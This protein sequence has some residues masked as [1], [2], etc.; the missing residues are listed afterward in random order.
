[1]DTCSERSQ[2]AAMSSSEHW[3]EQARTSQLQVFPIKISQAS[4]GK[5]TKVPLTQHGHQDASFDVDSFDWSQAN[6][7]GVAM[8]E[9]SGLYALDIDDY[10]TGSDPEVWFDERRIPRE[11]RTHKTV[12][13]G[14]HRIYA[15]P[16]EW[17]SLGN[18]QNIVPGL[19]GRGEGGWIAFGDG[20]EV[21]DERL[22]CRL[23]PRV[24]EE[25]HREHS[26]ETLKTAN[27][28]PVDAEELE[29]KL[30]KAIGGFVHLKRRWEGDTTGLTDASA[31]G[32]DMSVA[33]LLAIQDF[34]Y[35]EIVDVLLN[36]FPNGQARKSPHIPQP[37]A[38]QRCAQRAIDYKTKQNEQ[39]NRQ[40]ASPKYRHEGL[41]LIRDSNRKP[42]WNIAN[43]LTL[44]SDHEEWEGVLA[45]NK[46]SLR[47]E[48]L[49]SVPGQSDNNYP[50]ALED[51]DYASAQAWFNRN[52]F[53]KADAATVRAAVQKACKQQSFDPLVDYL[54]GLQWDGIPRLRAWLTTYAGAP[55]SDYIAEVGLRWCISAVA[56]A[57]R[58]GCKADHMLVLEG[59]QGRKKS[60]ALAAL[61]GEDWF[62]D[63]LPQMGTKD[64]Q[65][66][67]RGKWIIEVGELEAMRR[68]VDAIKAFISRQVETYR[69]AYGR[70]EVTEQR[71]CVF[72]GTTNK[73]DWQ[74]DETGGRR[75]WP[76]KVG[77]IDVQSL[78]R[79]RDQLWAEAVVH[80]QNGE[81]WWL[82][83]EVVETAKAEV[84]ARQA[85]DPWHEDIAAIIEGKSEITTKQVLSTIGIGTNDM[86]PAL[87]KRVAKE[88][89][90]LGW[91]R[92]GRATRGVHKGRAVYVPGEGRVRE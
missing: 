30:Q 79:D 37:R 23:Q 35:D 91:Q 12:S 77:A 20:Y 3:K 85:D 62:S 16:R 65:S 89:V 92:Q 7:Y 33:Q 34:T 78:A 55:A 82:E 45:F 74:R 69:P 56:R 81:S 54:D 80:F 52:G 60:T 88:L 44:L 39:A 76:V 46:F 14:V 27:A 59:A 64:A 72:A 9:V 71:R 63:A 38:A 13:G 75:F 28:E 1:M 66:Y 43:A 32:M 47:R 25:L 87:S 86:T 68:E 8:G 21:V 26:G 90:A 42:V 31:S 6:G 57:Y 83:G 15:L 84:A 19:D 10:K 41:D 36:Y 24:C 11:T 61:A 58:P 53:P 73:D 22:P 5:W 48:L 40:A 18:R 50:R 49:R 70:E 51:D 4:N 2:S 29:P 17:Q 67:L